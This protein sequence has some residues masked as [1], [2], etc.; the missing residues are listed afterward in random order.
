MKR[1]LTAAIVVLLSSCGSS[2]TD[3]RIARAEAIA[4]ARKVNQN[5]SADCT[6]DKVTN[7]RRC[8]AGTF[9]ASPRTA[10]FQVYFLGK[11][12]PYISAGLHTYPGRKPLVRF[13]NDSKPYTISDDGGVSSQQPQMSVVNRMLTASTANVRYH[14]WPKGSRDM[15]V[16]VRGFREAWGRLLEL[17]DGAAAP[18]EQFGG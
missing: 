2:S 4:E 6:R 18:L 13:D 14:S 17:R 12:G 9:G 10:P 16:D 8:F 5:W 15:V 3:P 1:I 7:V 11:S